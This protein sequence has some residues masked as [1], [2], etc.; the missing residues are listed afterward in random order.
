MHA[1]RF[2]HNS[3]TDNCCNKKKSNHTLYVITL[4]AT[5]DGALPCLLLPKNGVAVPGLVVPVKWSLGDDSV[6]CAAA[7]LGV[8]TGSVNVDAPLSFGAKRMFS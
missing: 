2:F 3:N 4:C 7:T 6:P 5:S 8:D 1:S